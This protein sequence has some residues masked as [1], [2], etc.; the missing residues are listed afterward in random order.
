MI[1][2]YR[3][4]LTRLTTVCRAGSPRKGKIAVVLVLLGAMFAGLSADSRLASGV[5]SELHSAT[6]TSAV[7][8]SSNPGWEASP[9]KI[10][11][12]GGEEHG[13]PQ[14]AVEVTRLFGFPITDS[15]I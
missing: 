4:G 11:K 15:M 10:P 14:A 8:T 9:T 5:Q 6:S 12:T 2:I 13:L 3:H 1:D 7:P